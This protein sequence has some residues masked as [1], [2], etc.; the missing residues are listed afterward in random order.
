M[1][2]FQKISEGFGYILMT[3]F[4]LGWID[5]GFGPEYTWWNLIHMMAMP[6]N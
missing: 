2:L 6:V 1:T 5:I 4:M 3:V